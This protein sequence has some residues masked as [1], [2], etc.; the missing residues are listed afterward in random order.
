ML[1]EWH[2]IESSKDDKTVQGYKADPTEVTY[3][4]HLIPKHKVK[5]LSNSSY[6]FAEILKRIGTISK[7]IRLL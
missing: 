2:E 3:I 4:Y 6:R 1:G 5:G 7:I